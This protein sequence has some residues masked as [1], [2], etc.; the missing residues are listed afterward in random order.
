VGNNFQVYSWNSFFP[1]TI[2]Y[3]EL[4]QNGFVSLDSYYNGSG[5]EIT[6]LVVD[7]LSTDCRDSITITLDCL[8]E[9]CGIE[10][11]SIDELTDSVCTDGGTFNID[12]DHPPNNTY[13]LIWLNPADTFY[14]EYGVQPPFQINFD[15][16]PPGTYEKTLLLI[17]DSENPCCKPRARYIRDYDTDNDCSNSEFFSRFNTFNANGFAADY[18]IEKVNNNED[19]LIHITNGTFNYENYWDNFPIAMFYGY[20]I[21]VNG[22]PVGEYRIPEDIEVTIGPFPADSE[23]KYLVEITSLCI[24]QGEGSERIWIGLVGPNDCVLANSFISTEPCD[25]N[26]DFYFNIG[27]EYGGA[28]T[29]SFSIDL[30][31]APYADHSYTG[32][33]LQFKGYVTAGPFRGDGMSEYTFDVYDSSGECSFTISATA[34]LCPAPE[35]AELSLRVFLEG[36]YDPTTRTMTTAL[37]D[38]YLLPLSQPYNVPPWNYTGTETLDNMPLDVVDWVLVEMRG[39]TPSETGEATTYIVESKAGLLLSNGEVVDT[40]NES[41]SF[42]NLVQDEPYHI[43]VRHRNHLDVISS[44]Q[45]DAS[46]NMSYDFTATTN[47]AFGPLQQKAYPDGTA[48][49]F[50]GDYT[51]DGIIQTSDSDAWLINPASLYTYDPID[52]NLDGIVQITDYDTWYLN[53]SKIGVVE[54]RY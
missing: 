28:T 19:F 53:R 51:T 20:T 42:E 31:G 47:N 7:S 39:G 8:I 30:N 29:D 26:D 11:L 32:G 37:A 25:I 50:A 13:D 18:E 36:A 33:D 14:R 38:Q 2:S 16:I 27:F 10:N 40:N 41:L 54:I 12:F 44:S 46:S 4:D 43:V 9:L 23:T 15:S 5:N 49:L 1:A 45:V 17:I 35:N 21:L 3:T 22:V 24:D 34:P 6:F 48:T 52:G